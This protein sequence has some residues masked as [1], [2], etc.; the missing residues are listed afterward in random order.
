MCE[1]F[2]FA[3]YKTKIKFTNIV[4]ENGGLL[5][6][7]SGN[8][9]ANKSYILGTFH[10]SSEIFSLDDILNIPG[11]KKVLGKVKFIGLEAD[12]DNIMSTAAGKNEKSSEQISDTGC[13]NISDITMMP[14][15]V[16]YSSFFKSYEGWLSFDNRMRKQYIFSTI[17]K[18]PYY[19]LK[20]LKLNSLH[21]HILNNK[22]ET[23]KEI[24][25]DYIISEYSKQN[26]IQR[27]FLDTWRD[28]V[29]NSNE[30]H[31]LSY[32]RQDSIM[33]RKPLKVQMQ[34][35]LSYL[36]TIESPSYI[37]KKKEFEYRYQLVYD[38]IIKI[39]N[40]LADSLLNAYML[41]DMSKIEKV[42][43]L[44]W[45]KLHSS[46]HISLQDPSTSS[47]SRNTW[48]IPII[49]EKIS[50]APCLIA[51]GCRHLPGIDGVLD[52]LRKRGYTVL[53]IYN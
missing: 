5:W 38:S 15:K 42:D 13:G 37:K 6:E 33:F 45:I 48:W 20:A 25:V 12:F 41:M 9:L 43:S 52:R 10:G 23:K 17:G 2:R 4:P 46:G 7:I 14:A 27:F 44:M 22:P 49:V 24:P 18:K 36:D 32:T 19:W 8:G 11:L 1:T 34:A 47:I 3:D 16:Y 50:K 29:H 51:V 31:S 53:P 40:E 28:S 21:M 26:N 39:G 35:L 30:I